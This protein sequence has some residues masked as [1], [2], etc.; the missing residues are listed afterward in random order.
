MANGYG[1]DS[2]ITAL[3]N[4]FDWIVVPSSN[5]DGYDYTW[6]TVCK[7]KYFDNIGK[8]ELSIINDKINRIDFGEKIALQLGTRCVLVLT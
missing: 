8:T 2:E 5:P 1:T 4:K 6:T 7:E 3:L